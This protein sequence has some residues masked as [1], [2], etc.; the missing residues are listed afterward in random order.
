MGPKSDG[1]LAGGS[2]PPCGPEPGPEP[3][4]EVGAGSAGPTARRRHDPLAERRAQGGRAMS[5]RVLTG[6]G[7][8]TACPWELPDIGEVEPEADLPAPQAEPDDEQGSAAPL[9]TA[10]Q[11]EEI[12]RQAREEG[13][14]H[15]RE[16][17]RRE[18]L[19]EMRER[20]QTFSDLICA[21]SDPFAELDHEVE[22]QLIALAVALARQLVR[23]EVR[24]DPGYILLAVREA[25]V[26]LPAAAREIRIH[27]HPEDAELIR[28]ALSLAEQER[29]WQLVDDPVLTRGDCRVRSDSSQID[30]RLESRLNAAIS[31]VFGGERAG[32]PPE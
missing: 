5:S 28:E 20:A 23:R 29:P 8:T 19:K 21:L 18:G 22:E 24:T 2:G 1:L 30:A 14:S 3:Y 25:M 4:A 6:R 13:F 10:E 7:V 16:E 32:D 31:A 17:G 15:G 12:Q 9:L 11:L 26:A 27:V